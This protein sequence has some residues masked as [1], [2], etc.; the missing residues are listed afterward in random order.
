MAKTKGDITYKM[1]QNACDLILKMIRRAGVASV[2]GRRKV[3]KKTSF[4]CPDLWGEGTK[5]GMSEIHPQKQMQK[6]KSEQTRNS[7]TIKND[8]RHTHRQPAWKWQTS[9]RFLSKYMSVRPA[10]GWRLKNGPNR[11][12]TSPR[13]P[14]PSTIIFL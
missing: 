4:G 12:R 9:R 13:P 14:F 6:G 2:L 5:K 8:D 3:P 7:M 11:W 1:S 10:H